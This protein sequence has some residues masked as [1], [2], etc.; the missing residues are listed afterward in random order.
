MGRRTWESLPRRPL[1]DRENIVLSN[2][3]RYAPEGARVYSNLTAALS[4]ARAMAAR[5]DED[6]VFII[7]GAS[8]YKAAMEMVDRLYITEVDAA[9]EGDVV[10]PSIN[11]ANWSERWRRD[12]PANERNDHAMTIRCLDRSSA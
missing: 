9:P 11:E 4:V 7:G 10:F 8:L 12:Y 2:D 3:W 6:E 5:T 1:P